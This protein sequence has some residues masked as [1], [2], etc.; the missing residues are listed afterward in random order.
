MVGAEFGFGDSSSSTFLSVSTV[1]FNS[2]AAVAMGLGAVVGAGVGVGDTSEATVV[3][4]GEGGTVV[5]VEGAAA[6]LSGAI[7]EV[8]K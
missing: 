6:E 7:V 2:G 4:G 8:V 1:G 5:S 3:A